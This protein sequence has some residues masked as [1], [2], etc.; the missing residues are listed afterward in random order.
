VR[1][2]ASPDV[3]CVES[4]DELTS[5]VERCDAP[6]YVRWSRHIERD[7]AEECSRDELSGVE[8]PGL[9]ANGL[10]V[11]PWWKS[12]PLRVWLARR[13]YDY[14]HLPRLRGEDTEPWVLVGHEIGRGPDNEPLINR[15]RAVARISAHVIEE[16]AA[17][18][19]ELPGDW[20]T[21]RRA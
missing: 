18:V 14:R 8:L 15:C 10:A 7:I 1:Q 17:V 2:H 6:L 19:D 16:A 5:L 13:L 9:S 4:L 21:L 11:E 12:R 20:G 3:L